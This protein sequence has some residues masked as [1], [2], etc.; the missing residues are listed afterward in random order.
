MEE[1]QEEYEKLYRQDSKHANAYNYEYFVSTRTQE[2]AEG[3][4]NYIGDIYL[5][6]GGEHGIRQTIVKNL[7]VK[8]GAIIQLSDLFVPGYEKK[9]Q[10]ILIEE[11]CEQ[12][13]VKDLQA[14]QEQGIFIDGRIYIPENFILEKNSITF[15]YCEDEI[16]SHE[17][18]EIRVKLKN[19]KLKEILK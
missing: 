12:Q 5:Y 14:L 16:A 11:L 15:I 8:S 4:L 9:L 6:G 17:M 1:Y 10:E 7:Q 18:G 2:G 13:N 3:I 19:R